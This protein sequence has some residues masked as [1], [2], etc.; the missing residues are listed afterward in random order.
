MVLPVEMLEVEGVGALAWPQPTVGAFF[1]AARAPVP[2]RYDGGTWVS[3]AGRKAQQ[4]WQAARYSSHVAACPLHRAKA[5]CPAPG[6][7]AQA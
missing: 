7:V 2:V 4:D 6:L 5:P 3:A 1:G